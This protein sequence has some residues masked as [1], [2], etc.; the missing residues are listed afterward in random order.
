MAVILRLDVD[1]GNDKILMIS[2]TVRPSDTR[3]HSAG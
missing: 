3:V 1:G 2:A